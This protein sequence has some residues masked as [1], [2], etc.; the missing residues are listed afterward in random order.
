MMRIAAGLLL[1]VAFF[2]VQA[3]EPQSGTESAKSFIG[4]I[5]VVADS[6]PISAEL[7]LEKFKQRLI[8]ADDYVRGMKSC[9]TE[10]LE[11]VGKLKATRLDERKAEIP[12]AC[13]DAARSLYVDFVA[14]LEGFAPDLSENPGPWRLRVSTEV[15]AIKNKATRARL[16]CSA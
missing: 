4:Y 8:S 7:L 16:E 13:F 15:R 12:P 9:P 3:T 11:A 1:A 5:N 2:G 6:C 14:H 10:K